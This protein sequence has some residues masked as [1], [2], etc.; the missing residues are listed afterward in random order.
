MAQRI[1]HGQHVEAAIGDRQPLRIGLHQH[2]VAPRIQLPAR[3]REHAGAD[4]EPDDE[5]AG[6]RKPACLASD[7]PG[8]GGDVEHVVAGAQAGPTQQVR[9]GSGRRCLRRTG[10]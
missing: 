10:G 3:H 7:Q 2:Q 8:P 4:V 1:A 9:S 6:L 5:P